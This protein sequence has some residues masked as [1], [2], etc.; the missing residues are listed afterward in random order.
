MTPCPTCRRHVV[1]AETAC[2]FCG[3]AITPVPQR[4]I[5]AVSRLTRSAVFA[6]AS[7]ASSCYVD[8]TPP[9]T[10]P[11]QEQAP[12]RVRDH[13]HASASMG[14]IH[15]VVTNAA[16]G[17]PV[18]QTWIQ[19]TPNPYH[20]EDHDRNKDV[21][22]DARG[23]YAIELPP[24]NYRL[25]VRSADPANR[26]TDHLLTLRIGESLTAD[27]SITVAPPMP[28]PMPYGAPPARR[29]LV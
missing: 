7:L 6:G 18:A 28:L 29:R 12:P 15:G 21:Y 9:P 13:S 4:P 22:T 14:A 8:K 3:A 27:F 20:A 25:S 26:P 2:P 10:T 24:G 23:A 1:L 16:N 5:I 19:I 11:A 17:Q